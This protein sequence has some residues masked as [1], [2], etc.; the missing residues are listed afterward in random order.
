M[1]PIVDRESVAALGG[2]YF[3]NIARGELVDEDA[4][5]TAVESGLLAGCAVDV[6]RNETGPNN[7]ARW[8]A[9]TSQRNVIVTPHV[10]GATFRSMRATEEFVAEKLVGMLA[11]NGVATRSLSS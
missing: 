10:G 7:R 3:V 6:I 4:L 9:A 5:L 1:P 11:K 8:I 2:R